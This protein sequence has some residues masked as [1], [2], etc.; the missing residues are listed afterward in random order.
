MKNNCDMARDLMP[1]T[2]DGVASAASQNYVDEHLEECEACRAYLEGMKAA[3]A[4]NAQL[5]SN[6]RQAFAD[7]AARM[8]R[9]RVIRRGLAV[10]IVFALAFG[11]VFGVAVAY[12]S[13]TMEIPSSDIEIKMAETENGTIV[14]MVTLSGDKPVTGLGSG[15]KDLESGRIM[16]ISAETYRFG[17]RL[18][19]DAPNLAVGGAARKGEL[20]SFIVEILPEDGITRIE[21][22]SD[23]AVCWEKGDKIPAASKE[24]EDYYKALAAL[25]DFSREVE[26]RRMIEQAETGEYSETYQLTPEETNE[27]YKLLAALDVARAKVPEWA[28]YPV[29]MWRGTI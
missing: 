14:L 11:A 15:S 10:L 7:T 8:K 28:D 20:G 22:G 2:I 25:E 21:Y 9:R 13:M 6:E 4:D 23:K 29:S 5:A 26:K 12:N 18:D 3:L 19:E 27:Y 17:H 24:M 1:L 16:Q